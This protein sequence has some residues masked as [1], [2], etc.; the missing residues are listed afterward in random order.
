LTGKKDVAFRL[1]DGWW[2]NATVLAVTTSFTNEYISV[3]IVTFVVYPFGESD[4]VTMTG[5]EAPLSPRLTKITITFST[6]I[7]RWIHFSNF[8]SQ[9]GHQ[10]T[11]LFPNVVNELFDFAGIRRQLHITAFRQSLDF[12]N[13][14]FRWPRHC[15]DDFFVLL[16]GGTPARIA[17]AIK[18]VFAGFRD[19]DPHTFVRQQ[20]KFQLGGSGITRRQIKGLGKDTANAIRGTRAEGLSKQVIDFVALKST[21][22]YF[23]GCCHIYL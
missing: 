13:I 10:L 3:L 4:S 8:P 18:F 12:R 5:T 17:V 15:L 9:F 11:P 16:T 14:N 2:Y 1:D 22:G 19:Q 20:T 21:A 6:F 23:V 7:I